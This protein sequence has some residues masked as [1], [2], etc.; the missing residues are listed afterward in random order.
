MI[1]ISKNLKKLAWY[2]FAMHLIQVPIILI[3]AKLMG[4][5]F[6]YATAKNVNIVIRYSTITIVVLI[7]YT[8]FK[9]FLGILYDQK[10]MLFL[11]QYKM[12]VYHQ[13][14]AN[15]L[16]ILFISQ[17]G[18]VI[19]KFQDDF[20]KVTSK[21]IDLNPQV[22]INIITIIGYSIYICL[23]CPII[24]VTLLTIS[25]FQ[26]VPPIIVKK[27]MTVNYK[28]T[29][30][31]EAKIINYIIEGYKNFNIIK[32]YGLKDYYLNGMKKLHKQY[33]KI[34]N[35][36]EATLTAEVSLNK[37]VENILKYG[38]YA[39]L[40]IFV[41]L[42]Y[43]SVDIGVQ[44][45]ALSARLFAAVKSLFKSI[46]KFAIAKIAE[47]RLSMWF[48]N[49]DIHKESI[50]NLKITLSNV[51]Y[52]IEN[53]V[54]FDK[55]STCID[56]NKISLI[57]GENGA[58]K[59]TLIRLILG[60]VQN[61]KGSI[62]VGGIAPNKIAEREYLNKLFYLPQEDISLPITANELVEMVIDKKAMIAISHM[63][64]FSLTQK[65]IHTTSLQNLSGGERKKVMLSL[66]LSSD[67][68]LLILDEPTNSLDADS[69]QV[70]KM[71][72]KKRVGGAI[73]VTHDDSFENIANH[74]LRINEGDISYD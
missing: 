31:I 61:K 25:L 12:S 37:I 17:D 18:E 58:G 69:K 14:L 33:L 35:R 50:S 1:N 48:N 2:N 45:I 40:G 8:L 60:L 44:A 41:L 46:P 56:G 57:K 71:K 29:R 38:T 16:N 11:H 43:C 47:N 6:T 4:L 51:N 34:G 49:S 72:L 65:A 21:I 59:S 28:Q 27:Y 32:L 74:V 67:T 62:E 10:K 66:A 55:L 52:A 19:E 68:S 63:Q 3:V 15:P 5:I 30:V 9:Y 22:W 7:T 39:I 53:K 23:L 54:I 42:K 70:L 20:E 64:D 36:A 26:I 13:F 73:I 24:M